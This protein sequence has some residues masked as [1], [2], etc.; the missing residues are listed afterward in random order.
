MEHRRH[1]RQRAVKA[2]QQGDQA[3][4]ADGRIGQQAL[5]IVLKHR[6][7]RAEHQG[8][9]PGAA[10]NPEPF[11]GAG[12]GRPQA[13]QQEHPGLDHGCRV[14]ISRNRS[15]RRHGMGQP[16]MKRE[17]CTFAKGADEDQRQQN[18]VQAVSFDLVA[19][20]Q[21][22][23]QIIAADNM[24]EQHDPRQ[25]AQA[26]RASDHQRHIGAAS[27]VGAV[28]PIADQQER[29]EAGQLPEKYDLDQV[30][31][32]HQAEHRAHKR[33]EKREEARHRIFG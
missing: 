17:L 11:F 26:P 2:Q 23:V 30:T 13:R 10:D 5:E 27:G 24:A 25:Q 6:A 20:G 21:H 28:M 4:V 1:G 9:G 19:C 29:E 7:V 31:R 14:Q 33:Q 12:Q 22:D 8:A 32:N 18:G 16:E 3:Q 15:R